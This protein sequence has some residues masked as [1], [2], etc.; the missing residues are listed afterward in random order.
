VITMSRNTRSTMI[1]TTV[2]TST[3]RTEIL[4][5]LVA[6]NS[7]RDLADQLIEAWTEDEDRQIQELHSSLFENASV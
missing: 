7:A 6:T 3:L 2:P 5:L 4:E 1:Q